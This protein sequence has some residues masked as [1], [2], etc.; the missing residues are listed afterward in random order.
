MNSAERLLAC[1]RGELPD[2]VP[3]CTYEL[4]GWNGESFENRHESYRRLM[5]LI[6]RETDCLYMCGVPIPNTRGGQWK[7]TTERWDEGDQ[8]VTRTVIHTPAR[9]LTSVRS[10]SDNVMTTWTREHPVKDLDDL[11]AY[12]D[13]PWEP[14]SPDFRPLRKAWKDLD[15]TRGLPLVSVGDPI[16]ELAELFEFGEFMVHAMTQ[17]RAMVAAL[18]RLHERHTETLKRILTG[19]VGGAVFRICGP[20]YATPPFLPPELFRLMVT[21]Y[22]ARYV[23]MIQQAGAFARIHCHGRIRR[24][25][26]QI[27]E[28]SPDALDPIEPPPDGDIDVGELK[29]AAGGGICL[30]GGIELKHLEIRSE[31]FVEDLVRRTVAAGKPGG[32]FVIMP[33][34]APINI[35]LSAKTERNYFRFIK[36]ALDSGAY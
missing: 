30:M 25:L 18:D 31:Q 27:A 19:P 33:T 21:R 1:L 4:V 32:R 36:T 2:R 14:G 10:R 24:V 23:R 3:I 28:M 13:L 15:G 6:R 35:P 9:D 26:D 17:T 16:C 20:E 34:A 12:L 22:D 11:R 5:D 29:A 7:I 8:H